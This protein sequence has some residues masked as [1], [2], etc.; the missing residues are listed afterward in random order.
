MAA[1]SVGWVRDIA[2][3][4][5]LSKDFGWVLLEPAL[6][7]PAAVIAIGTEGLL[8]ISEWGHASAGV[9]VH[10]LAELSW[11]IGNFIWMS[12]ELLFDTKPPTIL[13]WYTGTVLEANAKAYNVGA[14]VSLAILCFGFFLLSDYYLWHIFRHISSG[15]HRHKR[16]TI[17][18]G[19]PQDDTTCVPLSSQETTVV[20]F[21]YIPEEI[22]T[23]MF[24]FPWIA[25]DICWNLDW[26]YS[27][28]FFAI[29][30]VCIAL[31]Y[32][33]R[34]GGS[35]FWA[36]LFWFCGNAIW[37][38]SEVAVKDGSSLHM[39]LSAACLLTMGMACVLLPIVWPRSSFGLSKE[40]RMEE[41][42]MRK[43]LRPISSFARGSRAL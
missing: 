39:R 32:V 7:W 23:R 35:H 9:R 41:A 24:L 16:G 33:R 22:Y 6:A 10:T 40:E 29:L 36:E 12:S 15:Q 38:L 1:E 26:M 43:P 14:N 27:L 20:V 3:L 25:K 2:L 34:Y 17:L 18:A 19:N 8:A 30:V 4:A 37:A 21:G 13:P 31:D 5:W 42:A 28:V 11:L